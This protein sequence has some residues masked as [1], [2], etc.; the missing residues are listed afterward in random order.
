MH[1]SYLISDM[2]ASFDKA[3]YPAESFTRGGHSFELFQK[4]QLFYW[5]MRDAV[6][7]I[8]HDYQTIPMDNSK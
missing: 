2:I 7:T 1:P 4:K 3:C 6:L 8:G 5:K